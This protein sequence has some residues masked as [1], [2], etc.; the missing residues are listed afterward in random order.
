[1]INKDSN[2]N[3]IKGIASVD[4]KALSVISRISVEG[5]VDVR[6]VAKALK[7]SSLQAARLLSRLEN[8]GW[9]KRAMRGWYYVLPLEATKKEG[10]VANDPWIVGSKLY[11]PCYIG[12][13]SAAEH[14]EL[15]E[16]LF[17]ETFI[18]SAKSA[19]AMKQNI[20]GNE[21]RVVRVPPKRVKQFAGL[22]SVW[23]GSHQVLVSDHERTIADGLLTPGWLG[24]F[25][26][27]CDIFR[28]YTES[29]ERNYEKLLE[30][31]RALNKGAAFKRMGFLIE[32]IDPKATKILSALQKNLTTGLIKLDPDIHAKG[33]VNKT[34]GV[35]ENITI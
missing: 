3:D 31:T 12:G 34:W 5:L 15:T 29:P 22:V 17:R 32:L 19:R 33:K 9:I 1:M 26:H 18:I 4:K 16:Q 13:W 8:K 6:T 30:V 20:L 14:W 10:S 28:T 25:R 24:G 27:L 2:V 21:Y 7:F 23:R 35:W 11:A